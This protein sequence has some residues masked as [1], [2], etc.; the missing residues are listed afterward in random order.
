MTDVSAAD[1]DAPPQSRQTRSG[2]PSQGWAGAAAPAQPASTLFDC[3]KADHAQSPRYNR[4]DHVRR[5]LGA[6]RRASAGGAPERRSLRDAV[7]RARWLG[8]KRRR[9]RRAPPVTTTLTPTNRPRA[10]TCARSRSHCSASRLTDSTSSLRPPRCARSAVR[11][12]PGVLG[13]RGDQ[14][15]LGHAHV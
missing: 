1:A 7:H 8:D 2:H 10:E 6:T 11:G 5:H 14:R 12:S 4:P 3:R 13:K 9:G 15:V